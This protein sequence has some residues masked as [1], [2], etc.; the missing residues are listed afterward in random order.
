MMMSGDFCGEKDSR[1]FWKRAL[2]ELKCLLPNAW[3]LSQERVFFQSL[4]D[5]NTVWKSV[6][7]PPL[8]TGLL[9]WVVPRQSGGGAEHLPEE[10]RI[11][12]FVFPE[13]ILQGLCPI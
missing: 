11:F 8:A 5:S 1:I 9:T 2:W 12:L 4:S 6:G 3:L 7:E 10:W 13:N